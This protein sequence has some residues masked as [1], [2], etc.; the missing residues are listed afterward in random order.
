MHRVLHGKISI[1]VRLDIRG[2]GRTMRCRSAAHVSGGPYG[3]R[4]ATA[5]SDGSKAKVN[6]MDIIHQS[7]P[8]DL[9]AAQTRNEE[10]RSRSTPVQSPRLAA[11]SE[12]LPG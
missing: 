7:N 2:F 4:L 1:H 6:H 11:F 9:S 10:R 5:T 3:P 8:S 12:V